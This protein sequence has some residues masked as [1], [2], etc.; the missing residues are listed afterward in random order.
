[1]RNVGYICMDPNASL[2]RPH[3]APTI[4]M[5]ETIRSLELLGH[6]VIPLLYGDRIGSSESAIR[7]RRSTARRNS[8]TLRWARRFASD[9]LLA[10]QDLTLH[11]SLVKSFLA[12]NDIAAGYERLYQ[13][14]SIVT[15]TAER[16]DIPIIVESNSPAE[17]RRAY[18]GSPLHRLFEL[19]ELATLRRAAAVVVVSSPLK[20]HYVRKGIEAAK[21]HVIPNGVDEERFTPNA[22][23]RD[24]RAELDLGADVVVGFV[25]NVHEYHGAEFLIPLARQFQT[26]RSEARLLVV[27][28][29]PQLGALRRA[30]DD[31]GLQRQFV[32]TGP[33]PHAEVP[34]Y[35]ATMDVGVLPDFSW[36]GS[37]MKLLEYAAMGTA[38]VAPDSPNVRDVFAHGE[39]AYLF[40]PGDASALIGAV[41][42]LS[43]D[44]L[45]R[46]SL[47]QAARRHVI[48]GHTWKA[49]AVRISE[50]IDSAIR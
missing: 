47:G 46:R 19:K 28:G 34:A 6:R 27:G 1:M 26:D 24:M 20:E 44:A 38:V 12:D 17:E 16:L 41:Q 45:L 7:D 14:R 9:V 18:W 3:Y 10:A 36:Y 49:N 25:G 42:E 13:P 8:V 32:I 2:A 48:A 35:I 43:A 50:I 30:V 21:I 39:T 33:V 15:R 4:H 5:T 11:R 22:S 37:A 40:R 23:D 31:A 29:G